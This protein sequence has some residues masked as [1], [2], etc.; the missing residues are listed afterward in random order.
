VTFNGVSA[1]FTVVSDAQI[2]ATVPAG[3]TTGPISVTT[4][5]GTDTTRSNFTV[6]AY[7]LV[8]LSGNGKGNVYSRSTPFNPLVTVFEIGCSPYCTNNYALGTVVTLTATPG[9]GSDFSGWTGCDTVSG[10]TCTVTVDGNRTIDASFT[11]QRFPLTVQKTSP[12]GVGNGTVSSTSNPASP[13]QIDCGATCSVLFNY[14]SVVTLTAAPSLVSVF[15]GWTGCDAVSGTTCTVT[16]SAARSVT[17]NF[18]P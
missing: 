10:A 7:F 16:M 8:T 1:S 2:D 3:A 11:L 13:D 4:P 9:T 6:F 12:L 15:N 17:A 14:G 5:L 18:L